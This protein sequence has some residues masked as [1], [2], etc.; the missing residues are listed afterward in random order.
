[1]EVVD[2]PEGVDGLGKDDNLAPLALAS[3]TAA[4]ADKPFRAPS[5][6]GLPVYL[7]VADQ[8]IVAEVLVDVEVGENRYLLLRSTP[9]ALDEQTLS[10]REREIVRLVARGY[11]NKTIAEILEISPWTVNTYLR[12]IFAKLDVTSRAE[13]VAHSVVIGLLNSSH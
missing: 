5:L 9:P 3:P 6:A 1:M 7:N 8:H 2:G 12:R 10:P 4:V 13:M 11:P